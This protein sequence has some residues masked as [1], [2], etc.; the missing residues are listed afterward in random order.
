MFGREKIDQ[1][2]KLLKNIELYEQKEKARQQKSKVLG[3]KPVKRATNREK[4]INV[5]NSSRM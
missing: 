5:H 1:N 4:N 3:Q 2:E